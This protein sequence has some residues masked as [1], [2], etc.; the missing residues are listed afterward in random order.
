M[1][2]LKSITSD[3]RSIVPLPSKS[4]VPTTDVRR[5]PSLSLRA[6]VFHPNT[7]IYVR[8]LG[9][10]FKTGR[11]NPSSQD[12]YSTY[13]HR[14]QYSPSKLN[15][16]RWSSTWRKSRDTCP[17]HSGVELSF[18]TSSPLQITLEL[19]VYNRQILLPTLPFPQPFHA[20]R[21]DLDR[22]R[23]HRNRPVVVHSPALGSKH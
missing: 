4:K 10:C 23:N 18:Q 8:L 7:R 5:H 21:S 9:P 12:R 20:I 17:S 16:T 14:T 11:S 6:G 13:E 2:L 3:D 1:L 15:I 22:L 19:K